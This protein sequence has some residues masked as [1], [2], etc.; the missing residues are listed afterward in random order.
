MN[1]FIIIFLSNIIIIPAALLCF[2]PMKNQLKP[3]FKKNIGIYITIFLSTIPLSSGII[4]NLHLSPNS[5]LLPE[6]LIFFVLYHKCLKVHIS[7]SLSMF[8]YVCALLAILSNFSNGFDA[9]YNPT[10]GANSYSLENCLFQLGLYV[11]MCLLLY[12][13]LSQY[14]SILFDSLNYPKVWYTT[15]PISFLFFGTNLLIRPLQYQTLYTNKVFI[16]FWGSLTMMILMLL[17]LTIIFYFIV[18]SIIKEAQT[19]EK[20]KILEMQK[21]QY[22]K[23]QKYLKKILN[24]KKIIV[25][26][27]ILKKIL[28]FSAGIL[29]I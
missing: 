12:Y 25:F 13:P 28:S 11:V 27:Y 26:L 5:L 21:T 2:F 22:I 3:N 4:Y 9:I 16:A 10:L 24:K 17:L 14:G 23:Q 15:I 20:N 1:S 7:K 6:L 18:T 29:P 19:S 8:T